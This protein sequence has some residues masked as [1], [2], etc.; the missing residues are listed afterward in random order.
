MHASGAQAVSANQN[1][2]RHFLG[3]ALVVQDTKTP[4]T[5]T[6]NIAHS[7]NP[8]AV[9]VAVT[10]KAGKVSGNRLKLDQDK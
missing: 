3:N 2:V 1:E 7:S 6:E 5:V 9:V 8:K 10:G 4:A